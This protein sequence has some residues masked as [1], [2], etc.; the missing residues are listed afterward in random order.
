MAD[1]RHLPQPRG[2]EANLFRSYNAVLMHAIAGTVHP[3]TEHTVED[4]CAFAWAKFLEKQPDRDA[5]WQ[6]WLFRTAQRQAW[7]IDRRREEQR[8]DGLQVPRTYAPAGHASPATHG[9]IDT[10]DDLDETLSLVRALPVRLQRIAMLRA[11][12]F[13][14]A[15]IGELT[16]DSVGRVHQLFARASARI[17][18]MI[19]DRRTAE[20]G[21]ES[22][23]AY[24]LWELER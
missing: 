22:P 19:A 5:N 21:H 20:R 16:G 6:G 8:S 7:L 4:A 23:R 11:L 18:A 14:Y 10:I 1:S 15:E 24:R 12:G 3:S 17:S 13:E 2:D 9:G